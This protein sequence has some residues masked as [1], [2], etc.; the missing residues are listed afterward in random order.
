MFG[1][2]VAYDRFMGRWSRL[3]A[4]LVLA[5]ADVPRRGHILDAGSGTGSLAFAIAECSPWARV[6]GIDPSQQ[7]VA[8]AADRNPFPDRVRFEVGDARQIHLGDASVDAALS[9]LVFNFIPNPEKA[10]S[11]LRRVIR[12]GGTL[13]AAVWDYGAGMRMLRAFWDAA[14]HID[15][16]AEKLDE[17]HMPLCRAGELAALWKQGA[18][19]DVREQPID[20]TMRFESFADYWDPFLLGQGPAGSYLRRCNGDQLQSLRGEIRRRLPA[21]TEE[22]TPIFLPARMWVVRGVVPNR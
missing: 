3:A 21:S 10:L 13:S 12:P 7:Y 17:K 9:L 4:P 6:S 22:N 1:D 20:I 11:E 2:A 14:V 15:P 5:F 16:D 18:M 8:F 19:E